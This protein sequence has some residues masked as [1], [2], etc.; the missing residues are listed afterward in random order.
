MPAMGFQRPILHIGTVLERVQP[1]P[2]K[3]GNQGGNK[4]MPIVVDSDDS[5]E[6]Q[7][8]PGPP[9]PA[10]PRINPMKELALER[11]KCKAVDV[12]RYLAEAYREAKRLSPELLPERVSQF[13]TQVLASDKPVD[14]LIDRIVIAGTDPFSAISDGYHREFEMFLNMAFPTFYSTE[15]KRAT[16]SKRTLASAYRTLKQTNPNKTLKNPRKPPNL[17]TFRDIT[18]SLEL[19]QIAEEEEND[20]QLAERN[21]RLEAARLDNSLV[22]CECCCNDFL[23]DDMVTC[24]AGHLF[25]K[26]CFLRSIETL[27]GEGRTNVSCLHFGG[28]DEV[29]P[30]DE[31]L[32]VLP[33]KVRKR[34]FATETANAVIEADIQGL[35]KC[36]RCGFAVEFNGSGNFNCPE[37]KSD[38]CTGCG[39]LPHPGMTCDVAKGI[40]KDRVIEEKMNEAVVRKCPKCGAQFMKEEGCNRMEC[41][42]CHIWIC[43]W[44]RKEIPREIGYDHFFRGQGSCPPN[45]CP[46]WVHNETLHRIEAVHAKERIEA[47]LGSAHNA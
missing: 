6:V 15:I 7:L 31:F 18:I 38:T 22:E 42:R 3:W 8:L 5:D 40:D 35:V 13:F 44:C 19:M 25:C 46:L 30:M 16:G 9:I 4:D 43:Y 34:F 2:P 28:C 11:L 29:I 32:R 24:R 14:N 21:R 41:P 47:D 39:G 10:P 45:R 1:L 20:R 26:N 27:L 37:C 36:C 23:R 12:P 33:E 17:L